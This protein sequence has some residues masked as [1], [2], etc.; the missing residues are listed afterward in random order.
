MRLFSFGDTPL[1]R[2]RN[3]WW[4]VFVL[5]AGVLIALVMWLAGEQGR[6]QAYASLGERARQSADLNGVL[7]RTVL[8][9]QR[10]LPLVL[11]QDRD[12]REALISGDPAALNRIDQK[13]ESL[14]PG[15]RASVI[16]L[17]DQSGLGV[18]ASNWREPTSFVGSR[19][20]FRAYYRQ[21]VTEGSAEHYALGN[22]S[23]RPG[24]YLSRRIDGPAGM[25]GVIV[26]KVE[27]DQLEEDWQRLEGITYVADSRGIV[28]VTSVPQWRFLAVAPIAAEHLEEIRE[29]L[30]FGDAPLA[31]SPVTPSRTLGDP[32]IV[33]A[34]LPGSER[35]S[36]FLRIRA[37]VPSTGWQLH[38]L[39][40]STGAVRKS[41]RESRIAALFVVAVLLGAT[42]FLLYRRQKSAQRA[43]DNEAARHELERR[44]AERTR[45]L[46]E[47]HDQLQM[48]IDQRL[49]AQASLQ[50]VQQ[51]LV[52]ANRLAI[53]GQVAAGVAHEINQ[54]VAAIRSYADNACTFL[55]RDNPE[56][57]G[58]NLEQ[59]ASLTE[60]IGVITDE[61]RAFSR[62]GRA[63]AGPTSLAEVIDGALLLLGS[64]FRQ[65]YG[66]IETRMPAPE[67]RVIGTR[68]RLE[69]V[70]INLLQNG[71]EAVES[72]P[73]GQVVVSVDD[74]GEQVALIVS[75]N[76]SGIAPEIMDAL[77]T[78]FNTSKEGGLGLGLVISKDIIGEFG[79]RIEVE[80]GASGSRFTVYLQRVE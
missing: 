25:L 6:S 11:A 8:E 47:A 35:D 45:D 15:T 12:I 53:L 27:F 67:L 29:S 43:A 72:R 76:G 74:S 31:P 41:M 66:S 32:D 52:Q 40:P 9:K 22:V 44:V 51:E 46:R 48:Q 28:L 7:L 38:L 30:Q 20:D 4:T 79:G 23:K 14:I 39:L 1:Q 75:D 34:R 61:L 62:K 70:L 42:A 65:R 64:R 71:L 16:Y 50:S 2:S 5:V 55:V 56:Q 60:R 19:Y 77:F 69:Q 58:R 13:L 24:L 54:P 78:P 63:Q 59:I 57:A 3:I 33:R 10:S 17:L 26:V 68:I 21:A 37:D 73:D 80:T 18:A 49:K 36:E